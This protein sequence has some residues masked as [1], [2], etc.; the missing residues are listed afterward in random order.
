VA[1]GRKTE[2]DLANLSNGE[3]SSD[4]DKFLVD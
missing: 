1:S 4:I 2:I 3:N